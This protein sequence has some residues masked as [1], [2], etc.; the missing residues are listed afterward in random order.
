LKKNIQDDQYNN[1]S[2]SLF[3]KI[4]NKNKLK[5]NENESAINTSQ[6]LNI[7]LNS[8]YDKDILPGK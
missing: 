3:T 2:Q 7:P 5:D 8:S 6:R 4:L 1:N